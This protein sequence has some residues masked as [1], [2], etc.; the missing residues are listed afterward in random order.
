MNCRL[1]LV[2][3]SLMVLAGTISA[4]Q[5]PAQDNL[6]LGK[7]IRAVDSS[8]IFQS[9]D[10]Y[11]WCSSVIEGEDGMFHMFYSRWPHGRRTAADDTLNYIFDGFSGWN[12]Y[13][14]IAYAIADKPG[15]PYHYVKTILKGTGDPTRWD[16]FTYHNPL[17]RK[18]NGEYYLYFIAN[19]FDSAFTVKKSVT[20]QSLQWLRYNC[21]QKIGVVR[22][23]TLDGLI[24][25]Q[26]DHTPAYIMAPD[27][28]RTYEV[29]TNPAVT[30]GPDGKYYLLYKSR[31][32][33]VGHMTFWMAVADR[34]DGPFTTVSNVLAGADLACE[35][36][37]LWYDAGRKRFYAVAKYYSNAGK[38]APQFG[39]LVLITSIN[40]RDWQP[41]HHSLVSLRQLRCKNG[42]M[43]PLARLERP[44]IYLDEAGW[45]KALFAAAA[46]DDPG[47]GDP[48]KVRP[49]NNTFI[50]QIPL[51]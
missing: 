45:P 13:S 3:R 15:G 27:N 46:V 43:I 44:F 24:S 49:G 21:T 32:P 36:P 40:G 11:Q 41:A 20:P 34:P 6:D 38:L 14:E 4:R 16:R 42:Q 8:N 22:A 18:F 37:T 51:Q 48:E 30:Q 7:M 35:D 5:L 29:A 25:G 23:K 1:F 2:V 12:K 26:F 28:Q 47:K 50:V 39:A 33:E 9:P 10:Y 31:M 17:I 19:A